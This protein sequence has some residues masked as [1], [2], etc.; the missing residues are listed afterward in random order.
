MADMS[1]TTRR[2]FHV[3]AVCVQVQ[4]WGLVILGRL[5]MTLMNGNVMI[6]LYK[7]LTL[8]M[9]APVDHEEGAGSNINSIGVDTD[10]DTRSGGVVKPSNKCVH[11]SKVKGGSKPHI[12]KKVAS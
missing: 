10:T 6:S 8:L 7:L 11:P 3:A 4:D 1:Y 2:V 9:S 5:M 12:Q